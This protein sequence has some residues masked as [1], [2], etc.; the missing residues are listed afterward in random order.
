MGEVLFFLLH[1]LHLSFKNLVYGGLKPSIL[2]L[3]LTNN[4]IFFVGKF[5]CS[6]LAILPTPTNKQSAKLAIFVKIVTFSQIFAF[7]NILLW[8][9]EHR[10]LYDKKTVTFQE[11]IINICWIVWT[12]WYMNFWLKCYEWWVGKLIK[13]VLK[14]SSHIKT[15]NAYIN[16]NSTYLLMYL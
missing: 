11:D 12:P 6:N 13:V 4:I 7:W 15:C 2:S 9:T 8:A 14:L 10:M 1:F 3:A 16:N 5:V